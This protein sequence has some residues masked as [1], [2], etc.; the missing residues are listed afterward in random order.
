M[1]DV[2][3]STTVKCFTSVTLHDKKQMK[4]GFTGY[5][6]ITCMLLV[7]SHVHSDAIRDANR[8]LQVTN[9]G[10]QFELTAQR[11]TRD[12]I[13][14]YVSILSMS[15]KVALP[16]QIKNKIASCY[17]EV[18][19]WENFH[20]GIAQIFADNLN[21]KELRLL[22]DFYRDLGLPPMEIRAFKDL[23]SKAEQIQR[24]SA[25]YILVNSGSCV[26]QDAGLIHGY[27]ANRQLTKAVVI[28]D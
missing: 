22:I 2:L 18:Y 1:I 7:T 6:L 20:P 17:A 13:R 14:T 25:E 16:E 10:K 19:A 27:L 12:I 5:S 23:I 11:Q 26:D 8:L 28:A 21:Q 3:T 9:L 24:M 15:L 4:I